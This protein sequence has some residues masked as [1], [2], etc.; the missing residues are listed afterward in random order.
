MA[1]LFRLWRRGDEAANQLRSLLVRLDRQKVSI[2]LEIEQTQVRFTTALACKRNTVVV[3]KPPAL[4][5][6]LQAGGFVRFK[7]PGEGGTEIRMEVLTPHFNLTNGTPVFLCKQPTR[8]AQNNGRNAE[9]YGTSRFTNL[10]LQVPS[11]PETFRVVD[12][13]A[14]GC[15]I[16]TPYPRPREKF[17][18]NEQVAG[19]WLQLGRHVKVD[20]AYVIPRTFHGQ[21]IGL[22]FVVDP[23]GNQH[24]FLAHLI[25]S[26][27]KLQS[28][29]LKAERL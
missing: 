15:R 24:K 16:L 20:L 26:L 19:A 7:V 9:R 12:L 18:L 27:E 22:E 29:S 4:G 17:S 2:R 10:V 25:R 21:A 1:S 23:A 28:E 14:T 3:A 6:E 5:N 8:F 11:L 13:S